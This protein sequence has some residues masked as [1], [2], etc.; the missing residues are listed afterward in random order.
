[1]LNPAIA[2][3]FYTEILKINRHPTLDS[4]GKSRA[5]YDLLAKIFGEATR[6]EQFFFSTLFARISYVGHRFQLSEE[7]LRLVHSFRRA[8]EMRRKV[9]DYQSFTEKTVGLGSRAVAETILVL[10]GAAMPAELLEILP[11][12]D[13]FIFQKPETWDFKQKTRVVAIADDPENSALICWEEESPGQPVRVLYGLPER[14][15]NFTPTIQAIRQIIGFP[16]SLNLLEVDID[17]RGQM[18]PRAFV[19]EPDFL[20]DV[21]A[22]A[23]IFSQS[24]AEPLHFLVKKFLPF[25]KTPAILLG[26]V[27]NFFLDE[28]LNQPEGLQFRDLIRRAFL[29]DPLVFS[30][31]NDQQI[32]E[33]AGKAQKHFDNLQNM[34]VRGFPEQ[35]I[36][37]ADCHLEPS[38]FSETHGLQG[39]LDVFCRSAESSAIVELKSG[40]PFMPN[41]YGIG[42]SHFTQTLLYDLLVKEVFGR[43]LKPANYILYSGAETEPLK[44][45]PVVQAQQ[46]EA[47]QVRN[48]LVA[49]ERLLGGIAPGT[50][51]VPIFEKLTGKTGAGFVKRD[52]EL[53][54]KTYSALDSLEKKYLH[55]FAGFLAREQMLAKIGLHDSEKSNGHAALWLRGLDEKSEAFEV[56]SHLQLIENQ[57]FASDPFLVFER[58]ETTSPLANF[59]VGDIAVLWPWREAGD[60]ALSSQVIKCT[61]TELAKSSVRVS[62]R[63]RQSNSK[64]FEETSFWNLEHDVMDSSFLSGYR[65]LFEFLSASKKKRDLLLS[66]IAPEISD[67]NK[68]SMLSNEKIE[69]TE[70][71]STIIELEISKIEKNSTV[72]NLN[73]AAVF[74]SINGWFESAEPSNHPFM[75]GETVNPQ[76]TD[77]QST[78]FKKIVASRDYF[79]LWGPPGTGKTSVMLRELV[80]HFLK[81][82]AENL[83][84]LAFTNRAVDE[85][86]EAIESLGEAAAE[87]YIR[88]GSRHATAAPYKKR[89]LNSKISAATKRREIVE[90]LGRHRVFVGTVAS[91]SGS[92]EIFSLKKFHRLFVDEASQIL[93]PGLV[94]L[95]SR[96]EHFTLIGDHRQLPAVSAQDPKGTIVEDLELNSIGLDDLRDSLFERLYRRCQAENWHWAFDRLSHQ[97]RMH[98]EIMAFPNRHFYKGLL[99]IMPENNAYQLAETTD[100]L[101]ENNVL[102]SFSELIKNRVLFIPTKA[103]ETAI[104]NKTNQFEALEIAELVKSFQQIFNETGRE[105]KPT[106]L[107][108]ITPWRAQI[109]QIR[110]TLKEKEIDTDSITIDTVERYQGGARAIIIISLCVNNPNQLNSLVSLNN[111]GVDRKLNVALTRAREHVIVLGSEAILMRDERYADFIQ[112]YKR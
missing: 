18:R 16:I 42:V 83:L 99:K 13:D 70:Q 57:A 90:I 91:F 105:W 30:T 107:G 95:L 59:R 86:C 71:N 66:R 102:K 48:Q 34:V 23:E 14:N 31:L 25:E 10:T 79:L 11:P 103:D 38:F 97:G 77:E 65:S 49:I 69:L 3:P 44:F 2:L 87:G 27:A 67:F 63:A 76:L 88:I 56:L 28:L 43:S 110:A 112:K 80:H 62:L 29:L 24:G 85:I 8:V 40:K 4:D 89:L 104:G 32:H 12:A 53:F 68:N 84:L 109:A 50:A 33:I 37:P 15:D 106:T 26:N 101:N 51:R 41:S 73:S 100:F 21:S 96:F 45:A 111:E 22:V 36:N 47:L 60:S 19:V 17:R 108:I 92:Y 75:D 39:R 61:I 5:L 93:E 52:F 1:M 7:T 94:G 78:V 64:I 74:P 20:V 81:N 54:E 35:G 46:M 98:Q 82:T 6:Q 58:T 72:F 9:V 55:S